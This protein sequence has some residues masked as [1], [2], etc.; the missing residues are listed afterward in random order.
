MIGRSENEADARVL[1]KK[2]TSQGIK[3]IMVKKLY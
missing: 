2:L 1:G 3:D